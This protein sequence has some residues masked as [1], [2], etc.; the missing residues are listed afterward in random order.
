MKQLVRLII[1]CVL[2]G[3]L[4][5]CVRCSRIAHAEVPDIPETRGPAISP[6][7]CGIVDGAGV[8]VRRPQFERM[9]CEEFAESIMNFC[10]PLVYDPQC[11]SASFACWMTDRCGGAPDLRSER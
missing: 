1:L 11:F 10:E 2:S 4:V 5:L 7:A 6:C 8:C 9:T 3:T